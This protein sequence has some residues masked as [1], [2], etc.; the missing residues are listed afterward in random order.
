MNWDELDTKLKILQT[1]TV[2]YLH[3]ISNNY[4]S[5]DSPKTDD[6]FKYEMIRHNDQTYVSPDVTA[7][8]LAIVDINGTIVTDSNIKEHGVMVSLVLDKTCFYC[9]AGG[10]QNDIGIIKTNNGHI[11][12]VNNVEKIQENGVVLHYIKSSD[13]PLLLKYFLVSI[14]IKIII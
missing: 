7:K 12:N 10:Q 5:I 9:E 4:V 14:F 6:S 8:I 2:K 13:W 11:F 3:K 1:K